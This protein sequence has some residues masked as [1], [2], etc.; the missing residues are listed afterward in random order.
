MPDGPNVAP[1]KSGTGKDRPGTGPPAWLTRRHRGYDRWTEKEQKQRATYVATKELLTPYLVPHR[2]EADLE[3]TVK[4]DP[5]DLP[6]SRLGF[7]MKLNAAYLAEIFGHVRRTGK[8]Y[9]WGPLGNEEEVATTGKPPEDSVA[10]TLW[11]DITRE[12]TSWSNF[13][14]RIVM[15]WMLT[16]PGGFVVVDIPPSKAAKDKAKEKPSA[17]DDREE[18][19][20]PFFRF[21]PWSAVEDVGRS[22]TG[23]RY[24]KILEYVDD[25][26]PKDREDKGLTEYRLLY[27]LDE[28]GNTIAGRYDSDG[29]LNGDE[30]DLGRLTDRQGQARIPLVPVQFGEDSVIPWIG[31]ALLDGLDDVVIDIYNAYSEVREGFR[32]VAFSFLTHRG[33]DP[34]SVQVQLSSGSRFVSVGD[35]ENA[36]INRIAGDAGEVQAGLDLIDLAIRAWMLS[37]KRKAQ[38]A[39][40]S[41][42]QGPASGISLR[43][44]FELDLVPLLADIAGHLDGVESEC[45]HLA[46]QMLDDTV[47]GDS[48]ELRGIGVERDDDFRPEDEA[49]RISRI[50]GDFMERVMKLPVEGMADTLVNWADASGLFDMD[51]EVEVAGEDAITLR[52]YFRREGIKLAEAQ[53]RAVLLTASNLTGGGGG[54]AL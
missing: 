40:E 42:A 20:R 29:N 21:V 50:V 52:E 35:D 4:T 10:A 32:D 48:Q 44:E 1:A 53:E 17:A 39:S 9:N 45:M 41:R 3:A 6:R 36:E 46:V 22:G 24:V 43:A 15:E 12:N 11:E 27:T 49:S 23:F 14:Q 5:A 30:I 37:A 18:G 2:F 34:K 54:V 13:F 47:K 26:Q 8:T 31:G 7:A 19:R 28:Q 51:R 33:E 25:R 38:E 16:S